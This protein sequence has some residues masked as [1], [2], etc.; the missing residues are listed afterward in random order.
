MK[1]LFC[2]AAMVMLSWSVVAQ[3]EIMINDELKIIPVSGHVLIHVSV[4]H[5][6]QFGRVE[7][8]GVI[9][10]NGDE[11]VIM[12]TPPTDKQSR[13][14]LD[15]LKVTY[16]NVKVKAII[17]NHFHS[18][19]L[20][21]L[22]TFHDRGIESWSHKLSPGLLKLKKDTSE[23]PQK[24]FSESMTL[25]VGGKKVESF[26]PGEAHTRDNIVTWIADEKFCLVAAW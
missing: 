14:L 9:Y 13:E 17:V 11:A 5:T 15:W 2:I 22:K 23:I 3:T 16:Q 20:G 6:E 25:I 1:K 8:N 4:M 21:G 18:D 19:C 10:V 12:D 26:Y 24:T 7:A